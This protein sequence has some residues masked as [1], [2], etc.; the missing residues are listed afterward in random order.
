METPVVLLFVIFQ[1]FDI[2]NEVRSLSYANS[3]G[4]RAQ[5]EV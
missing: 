5:T 3:A 2:V 1:I 4:C